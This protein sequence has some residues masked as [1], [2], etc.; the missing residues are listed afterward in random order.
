MRSVAGAVITRP[1]FVR[2]PAGTATRPVRV[3]ASKADLVEVVDHLADRL[4]VGLDEP[5][6]GRDGVPA[7]RGQHNHRPSVGHRVRPSAPHNPQQTLAFLV[8]QSPDLDSFCH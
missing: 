1:V 4:F 6:D 8:R 5:R 7:G 3:Q 2:D